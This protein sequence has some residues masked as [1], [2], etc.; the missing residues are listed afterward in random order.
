MNVKSDTKA[1]LAFCDYLVNELG[2]D[3]ARVIKSPADIV[4]EKDGVQWF[5]EIKKTSKRNYFGAATETEWKQAYSD[6][7]HYRFVVALTEDN[8]E[9]FEW[10]IFTP[11][12]MEKVS[13]IPPFKV[14]FSI[15]L[16]APIEDQEPKHKS[17]TIALNQETFETLYVVFDKQRK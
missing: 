11:E 6:P 7:E 13:T 4:A 14:F 9:S 12:Q 10:F 16:D 8:E 1:K 17:S 15:N 2:Y 3:T 5:F